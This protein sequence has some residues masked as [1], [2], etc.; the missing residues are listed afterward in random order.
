[1]FPR[2]SYVHCLRAYTIFPPA[3]SRSWILSFHPSIQYVTAKMPYANRA[4]GHLGQGQSQFLTGLSFFSY[5]RPHF[6]NPLPK[7]VPHLGS[8]QISERGYRQQEKEWRT[9]LNTIKADSATM[10]SHL[11]S[12][13][14]ALK[15]ATADL[16]ELHKEAGIMQTQQENKQWEMDS[17]QASL[18]AVTK[19]RDAA[20]ADARKLKTEGGLTERRMSSM[21]C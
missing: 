11:K 1:M 5:P 15:Q 18:E 7:P 6:L 13:E 12:K 10:V 20:L 2:W 21:S 9:Q 8:L 4:R 14:A 19:E 3:Q 17:L 16:D